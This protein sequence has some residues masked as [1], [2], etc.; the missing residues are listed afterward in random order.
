MI[1]REG[2]IF[3]DLERSIPP[4]SRSRHSLTL[5]ISETIQDRDEVSMEYYRLTHAVLNSVIS[6]DLERSW[7]IYKILSDTKRR[8]VSLRQLSFLFSRLYRGMQW[9]TEMLPSLEKG[10]EGVAHIVS[11]GGC[12]VLLTH[13]FFSQVRTESCELSAFSYGRNFRRPVYAQVWKQHG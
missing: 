1:Y 8:A 7:V 3:N 11:T 5:N 2:A 9:T 4:V 6:N 10:D 12:C 13:L